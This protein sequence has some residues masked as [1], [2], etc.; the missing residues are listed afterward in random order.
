MMVCI[1]NTVPSQ[2]LIAEDTYGPYMTKEE[3]NARL[4]VMASVIPDIHAPNPVMIQGKCVKA[5]GEAT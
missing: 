1:I 2:C 5:P 4:G 3:C